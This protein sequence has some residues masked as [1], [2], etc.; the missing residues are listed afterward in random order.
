[1]PRVYMKAWETLKEPGK[2]FNGIYVS[3]DGITADGV[4]K[5]SVLWKPHLYTIDFKYSFICN[6]C[7]GVK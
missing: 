6:S 7:T 1:M 4:N 3:R 2:K 5:K